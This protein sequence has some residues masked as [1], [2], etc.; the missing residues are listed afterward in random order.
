MCT[1]NEDLE[2]D[3][4]QFTSLSAEEVSR[5]L[6][7]GKKTTKK[8]D[9]VDTVDAPV[10]EEIERRFTYH[11]PKDNQP[12]RYNDLRENAKRMAYLIKHSTK[13]SREQSLS[14]THLEEVVFWA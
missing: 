13:I 10:D 2:L 9:K 5:S 3:E 12:D 6:P 14:Y 4:Q 11:Q 7:K 1:V 8:Q